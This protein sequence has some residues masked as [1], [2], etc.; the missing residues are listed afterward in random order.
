MTT[1]CDFGAA[2]ATAFSFKYL[3]WRG[4]QRAGGNLLLAPPP[5]RVAA[6][7]V[8]RRLRLAAGRV[9]PHLS[10]CSQARVIKPA[11]GWICRIL[12]HLT[13]LRAASARKI[14]LA[15]TSLRSKFLS[16]FTCSFARVF[17]GG[18]RI[19]WGSGHRICSHSE[20]EGCQSIGIYDSRVAFEQSR[21]LL[22]WTCLITPNGRS[23][24]LELQP[25][26]DT[27]GYSG[28]EDEVANHWRALFK[29]A[30]LS[31]L[32]GVGSELGSTTSTNSN[33]DVTRGWRRRGVITD[34]MP[35]PPV[36]RPWPARVRPRG[37]AR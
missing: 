4:A 21:V 30:L 14:S 3:P 24:V 19:P 29:T 22:V 15:I 32:L 1:H 34:V 18:F 33:S 37:A 13:F 9:L 23:I 25:G 12:L 17:F 35:R 5:R 28:L 6:Q 16:V 8:S 31:T 10:G 7:T 36:Y 11:F 27:P 26:A 2:V 20:A